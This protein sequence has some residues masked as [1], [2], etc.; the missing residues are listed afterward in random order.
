MVEK[1]AQRV[2]FFNEYV[3]KK[4]GYILLQDNPNQT[5]N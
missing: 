2:G 1:P 4:F 5:F 3:D